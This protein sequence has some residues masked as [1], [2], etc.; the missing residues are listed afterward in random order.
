M[1]EDVVI[2]VARI[3]REARERV[4]EKLAARQLGEAWVDLPVKPE[5]RNDAYPRD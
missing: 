1:I 4:R 3:E 5:E 2:E